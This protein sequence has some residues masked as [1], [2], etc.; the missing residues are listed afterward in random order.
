MQREAHT[1]ARLAFKAAAAQ[2]KRRLRDMQQQR[3]DVTGAL[4][5][6]IDDPGERRV[7][8]GIWQAMHPGEVLA[9]LEAPAPPAAG[10]ANIT[11]AMFAPPERPPDGPRLTIGRYGPYSALH[12]NCRARGNPPPH[13]RQPATPCRCPCGREGFDPPEQPTCLNGHRGGS[14]TQSMAAGHV[15][16][17]A[18]ALRWRL[19]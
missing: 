4:V 14:G 12:T 7:V 3:Q 15:D 13:T 1:L 17:A 9:M 16:L 8:A 11:S 19:A 2:W 18:S 5:G 10:Q 6:L